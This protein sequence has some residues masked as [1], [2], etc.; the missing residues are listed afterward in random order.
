MPE[1]TDR[2]TNNFGLLRLCFALL[3]A[4]THSFFFVDGNSAREPLIRSFHSLSLADVSVDG[5]FLISGYLVTK[6]YLK[7]KS[8][9]EYLGKRVLR[10]YPGY[11]AACGVSL[12]IGAIAGGKFPKIDVQSILIGFIGVLFFRG[13]QLKDAFAHVPFPGINGSLWTI[14]YEFRCYLALIVLGYLRIFRYR[15]L[16]GGLS[17]L[18]VAA[19]CFLSGTPSQSALDWFLG[20]P[21][22]DVRFFALFLTGSVFYLF[23][24]R[25]QLNWKYVIAS[26]ISLTAL[27]ALKDLATAALALFGGYA[28][29]WF[30]FQGPKGRFSKALNK[31]DLSYGFYLYSWPVGNLIEWFSPSISVW[32][33]LLYTVVVSLTLAYLS[34]KIIEKPS[35]NL[36]KHLTP[37]HGF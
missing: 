27:L 22:D 1:R 31:T 20:N 5:F 24:D 29:F 11:I 10:I 16:V 37:E 14:A 33:L 32:R 36:K 13:V 3:V 15:Y 35:L 26:L 30:A 8:R 23:E 17:L 25:I 2:N 19:C 28:I 6:S 9:F 18:L 21:Y 7:S 4:F 34:W 12:L